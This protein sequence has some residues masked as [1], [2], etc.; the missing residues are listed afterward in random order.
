MAEKALESL[1]I[2]SLPPNINLPPLPK[3][4]DL[5]IER[6]VFTHS[7]YIA[8][9]KYS[10]QLFENEDESRDNEK[11][12]LLGDSLLDCA[13]VGLLQDLYPNLNPGIATQLKSNLVN[14]SILREL[15]KYYQLNEKLIA[16]PE[17]LTVLRNGEK[18]LANLFEAYIAGLYYSYLKHGFKNSN[19]SS[20]ISTPPKSPSLFPTISPSYIYNDID[21]SNREKKPTRGEAID[22]LDKWLRP[23]FQPIAKHILLQMKEKE[24]NARLSGTTE[25]FDT[26]KKA[27]GAN[28]RLNQW[29]EHKEKG[30]PDYAHSRAGDL[31][32]VLCIATDRHGKQWYGE[33]VRTTVKA[34]KAVAAYK[35]CVQFE[36]ERPDF[37]G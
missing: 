32:K 21:F 2:S 24:Q 10:I 23:L 12:E 22:Y 34:A 1:S 20:S 13:V 36:S 8:K 4:Q 3:I 17:Q 37:K 30:I 28:A 25:D 19:S 7:S 27:I 16:P 29:F 15:C 5:N 33:A 6:K 18:V 31:W 35:V 14:N 9:P 26:D 11:L